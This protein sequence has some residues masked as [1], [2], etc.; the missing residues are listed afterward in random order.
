MKIIITVKKGT[1]GTK[2]RPTFVATAK[3]KDHYS[4]PEHICNGDI[5]RLS[6]HEAVRDTLAL[7]QQELASNDAPGWMY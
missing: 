7:L 6:K 1:H 2:H 5:E 4:R 3:A